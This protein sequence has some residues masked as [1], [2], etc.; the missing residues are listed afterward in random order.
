V[1]G[2]EQVWNMPC[3][4][5]FPYP[6]AELEIKWYG[7]TAYIN[8]HIIIQ[9]TS[10]STALLPRE[11]KKLQ[12]NRLS[13]NWRLKICNFWTNQSA[14][15]PASKQAVHAVDLSTTHL[16]LNRRQRLQA[17]ELLFF[18]MAESSI[19]TAE[20]DDSIQQVL[21]L[22]ISECGTRRSRSAFH[23]LYVRAIDG[24]GSD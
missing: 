11:G 23:G 3:I 18:L 10:R 8:T 15:S 1:D 9:H 5:Y 24:D 6:A 22:A 12:R 16:I 20:V 7:E 21:V 13:M 2:H 19:G 14:T 4:R 17:T